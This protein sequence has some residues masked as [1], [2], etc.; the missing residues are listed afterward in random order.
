MV[1]QLK[2]FKEQGGHKVKNT[3]PVS[4]PE[5]LELEGGTYRFNSAIIHEGSLEGGH[6][7]SICRKNDGYFILNDD[8]FKPTS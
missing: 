6:Y 5:V 4:Y 3:D 1:F 2:R 8:T 7:W